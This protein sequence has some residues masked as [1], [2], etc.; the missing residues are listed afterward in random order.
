MPVNKGHF[1][2]DT[3]ERQAAFHKRLS[4]GW[5]RE[6]REY[7]RLWNELPAARKVR[8]YPLHIDMELSSVC[9][10][11]CPMCYTLTDSFS[12]RVE[13]KF[14]DMSLFRAV[15]DEAAP[16]IYALRLSLRGEATLHPDFPDAVSYAKKKGVRE[17]ST[18]TNG[19]T[20]T[21]SFFQEIAR[22]G[23][24]WLTVSVDGVG[25]T[26]DHIRRPLKFAD[27]LEKIRQAHAWRNRSG[28]VKPTIKVQTVWP[29]IRHDPAGYYHTL[30]P[31]SDLVAFNP[32]IDYLGKDTDIIYDE[33]FRCP[34][35]YQR[36]TV[37]SDGRAMVCAN[38]ACTSVCAGELPRQTV[39]EIWH[40]DVYRNMRQ[41]HTA[42]GGFHTVPLCRQCYYP[43]AV[44]IN[45]RACIDGRE[46]L[47]R[48]YLN[49]RQ[50]VGS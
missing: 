6:Y 1:S 35:I 43:R 50:K 26:Y 17:V 16:H 30:A 3:P 28:R 2:L 12:R 27:T 4:H 23:L 18:L 5:A 42:P 39:R 13:K 24:D 21:L 34:Q 25:E 11:K 32:L 47:V 37:G 45:E 20:L 38:D 33:N 31:C 41:V 8:A 46:I 40:G 29:A 22:A 49:R 10:L 44:E 14:M 9:N 36:L 7:R 19:S 48:N 15:I